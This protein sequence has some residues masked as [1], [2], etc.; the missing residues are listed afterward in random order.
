MAACIEA[1]HDGGAAAVE[2]VL[3]QYPQLEALLRQRL[4]KLQRAGLLGPASGEEE[5]VVASEVPEQLGEFKLGKRLGSG[6]MGIVFVAEQLSLGRTVALKLVRPEQR[7]FPGARARF[8]RE[9]EAIARLGD[10]GIV[11]IFCVGQD[12]GIDFFAMEYVRGASLGDVVAALHATSPQQLQG[13]DVAVVAAARGEDAVPDP[14]PEVFQGT[15]VQTCCRLVSLMPR[16]C[17]Y[18]L[19]R[20]W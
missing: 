6:G 11:P 16:S 2:T 14:L 1:W 13:R 7:F 9:V 4:E 19:N 10:A 18:L 15:W 20:A 8:R 12:Q 5:T 17:R 3:A